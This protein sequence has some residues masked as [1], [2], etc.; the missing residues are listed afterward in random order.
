[1]LFISSQA[2]NF[3]KGFS[4]RISHLLFY[5]IHQI[6]WSLCCVTSAGFMTSNGSEKER[7]REGWRNTKGRDV[8]WSHVRKSCAYINHL[9]CILSSFVV[10][11]AICSLRCW[12]LCQH[13]KDFDMVP[14]DMENNC[15]NFQC[16][17]I[18]IFF[19]QCK[20][21]WKSLLSKIFLI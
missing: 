12:P 6:L 13:L 20:V 9:H 15:A 5:T 8:W 16:R 3:E 1:M 17:N 21:K 19:I 18:N 14:H 7:E 2:N 10:G 11:C 4:F